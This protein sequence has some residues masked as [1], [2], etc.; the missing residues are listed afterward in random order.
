MRRGDNNVT[1]WYANQEQLFA[2][3]SFR[4]EHEINADASDVESSALQTF[5]KRIY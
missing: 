4:I 1:V 5:P 3:I 2:N